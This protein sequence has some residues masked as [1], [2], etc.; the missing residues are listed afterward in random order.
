MIQSP[1]TKSQSESQ[2]VALSDSLI[3][4]V[5][6]LVTEILSSPA[7]KLEKTTTSYDAQR[8]LPLTMELGKSKVGTLGLRVRLS[9]SL[10]P[11]Q[12][13][14]LEAT[15]APVPE[16]VLRSPEYERYL[17]TLEEMASSIAISKGE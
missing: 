3:G 13:V 6:E 10:K 15:S 16:S 5:H 8:V 1:N 12:E 17:S 14:C 4:I 11:A 9:L 2:Q 7:L